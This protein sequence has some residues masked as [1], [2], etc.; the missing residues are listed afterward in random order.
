MR[1]DK[2]LKVSRLVKRRTVANDLCDGGNVHINGKAAKAAAEVK[3]GDELTLYFGNRT[4]KALVNAVPEKA[5][6]VQQAPTLYTLLTD[7]APPP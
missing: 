4:L 7:N 5:V 1:L 6:S 2:F 3:P